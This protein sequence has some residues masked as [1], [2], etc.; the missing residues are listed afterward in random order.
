MTTFKKK[1]LGPRSGYPTDKNGK[2]LPRPRWKSSNNTVDIIVTYNQ[3]TYPKDKQ[4]IV[5]LPDDKARLK[6][7][8]SSLRIGYIYDNNPDDPTEYTHLIDKTKGTYVYSKDINGRDRLTYSI[9]KPTYKFDN[10]EMIEI[11]MVRIDH[12]AEH[13]KVAKGITK[14]YSESD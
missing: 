5:L 11:V 12:I 14:S 13:Q 6:Q 10:G 1:V 2:E 3:S 9:M 7:L 4:R 8:I